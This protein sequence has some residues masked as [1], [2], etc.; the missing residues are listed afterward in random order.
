MLLQ[1]RIVIDGQVIGHIT[2]EGRY[3]DRAAFRSLN[4]VARLRA[5]LGLVAPAVRRV[6]TLAQVCGLSSKTASDL[7]QDDRR[8][9]RVVRVKV[10]H[11]AL[12][13]AAWGHMMVVAADREGETLLCPCPI[14]EAA[15]CT[16]P[17][18]LNEEEA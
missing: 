12:V 3:L 11:Y 17:C 18:P 7:L 9:G 6:S 1:T 14:S 2:P 4:P 13:K 8:L 15:A 10:G 16:R 5:Y